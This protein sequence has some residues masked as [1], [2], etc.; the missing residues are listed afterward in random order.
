MSSLLFWLVWVILYRVADAAVEAGK[1]LRQQDN[2]AYYYWALECEG[3]PEMAWVRDT[4]G[5]SED[6]RQ[7]D[8]VIPR[9]SVQILDGMP[10]ELGLVH[11]AADAP[12][13]EYLHIDMPLL[14]EIMP[15]KGVRFV[16]MM[17]QVE[18]RIAIEHGDEEHAMACIPKMLAVA[19]HCLDYGAGPMEIDGVVSISIVDM[20]CN[21]IASLMA[22]NILSEQQS[23]ELLAELGWLQANSDPFR[24]Q[25]S[26][27]SF[28]ELSWPILRAICLEKVQ[29]A[30]GDLD[31]DEIVV[32]D[33]SPAIE[34]GLRLAKEQIDMAQV[35]VDEIVEHWRSPDAEAVMR[36]VIQRGDAGE[37]GPFGT[38]YSSYHECWKSERKI[39]ARV[40]EI[41]E[42]LEAEAGQ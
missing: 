4:F 32:D 35:G 15:Y 7:A 41:R 23:G 36:E 39:L 10:R 25:E 17:L 16:A 19:R 21:E 2:A 11:L 18:S 27:S 1:D 26:I 8:Y 34:E 33:F 24:L 28:S 40:A 5:S 31:P 6:F 29:D 13:C 14:T 38:S 22:C 12:R 30:L 20:A 42:M 3:L 37:Y 9:E